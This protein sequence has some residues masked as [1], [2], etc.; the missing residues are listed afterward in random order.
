MVVAV[1][2]WLLS[3]QS[4]VRM[5][6]WSTA[7]PN[8]PSAA[9]VSYSREDLDFVLRLTKDLK[10]KGAKVWMDK[11]DIRPGQRWE[12]EVEGALNVCS[13]MLVIVWAASVASKNVLAEAAYAATRWSSR[14]FASDSGIGTTG[15]SGGAVVSAVACCS[16]LKLLSSSSLLFIFRRHMI[17]TGRYLARFPMAA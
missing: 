6:P 3:L 11:L 10:A 5:W 9:F 17:D 2:S 14:S 12:I 8:D 7:L 4:C 16:P 1:G 15:C 13:R